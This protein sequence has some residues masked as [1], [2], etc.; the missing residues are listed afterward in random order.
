MLRKYYN[1][2]CNDNTPFLLTSSHSFLIT[3]VLPMRQGSPNIFCRQHFQS[4]SFGATKT[5]TPS[6]ISTME[7]TWER[8]QFIILLMSKGGGREYN[9]K[10]QRELGNLRKTEGTWSVAL[11]LLFLSNNTRGRKRD[12]IKYKPME[13]E[14]KN[15]YPYGS[16]PAR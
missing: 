6:K 10:S 1:W 3:H 13:T 5:V 16:V 14:P 7:P 15:F 12:Q 11:L 9:T 8:V 4:F 2:I